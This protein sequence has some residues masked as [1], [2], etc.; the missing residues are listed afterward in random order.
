M[1]RE[2]GRDAAGRHGVPSGRAARLALAFLGLTALTATTP[3]FPLTHGLYD[4]VA[5]GLTSLAYM[6]PA[7]V[8]AMALSTVAAG[9][10]FFRRRRRFVGCAALAL[11]GFFY[12]LGIVLGL[13][14]YADGEA[15]TAMAALA[16]ALGG[17]GIFA[18]FAIWW[19]IPSMIAERARSLRGML[20]YLCAVLA[21][22]TL[23]E[24]LLSTLG[25]GPA[26][27]LTLLLAAVAAMVPTCLAL[28]DARRGRAA[29]IG[30]PPER[31]GGAA[32]RDDA[33]GGGEPEGR[34][35]GGCVVPSGPEVFELLFPGGRLVV[36]G[37][38]APDE[39]HLWRAAGVEPAPEA[40]EA[41]ARRQPEERSAVARR[42]S[43]ASPF[44]EHLR[45]AS[46]PTFLVGMPVAVFLLY[47]SSFSA[48]VP[49]SVEGQLPAFAPSVLVGCALMAL[50]CLMGDDARTTAFSFR[51]F[52]PLLGVAILGAGNIV[53]PSQSSRVVAL[54]AQGM[55]YCYGLIVTALVSYAAARHFS[56]VTLLFA[57]ATTFSVAV[58]MM[59]PYYDVTLGGLS[60]YVKSFVVTVL[61]LDLILL[62][63]SPSMFAWRDVLAMVEQP[64]GESFGDKVREAC[65]RVSSEFGLTPREAEIL[66]YL[67]RGYG[68]SY[69]AT[70]MSIKENTV[71]S[72]V[73]NI[74]SK[75][76]VSSRTEL[77]SL[78]DSYAR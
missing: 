25:R 55:C 23:C 68:A 46:G 16:G 27:V 34:G 58:A 15:S 4:L 52:L 20:L 61:V 66:R 22:G 50:L 57:C 49:G 29:G 41:G 43:G 37:G 24:T 48:L 54:G 19:L 63:A 31:E 65:D 39:A 2:G 12:L 69:L 60:G 10:L 17:V 75:L 8:T 30:V 32:G 28:A 14:A 59:M 6:R 5:P 67:G 3:A 26:S 1:A 62:I 76:D 33:A 74:Y 11:G 40:G 73:R 45:G 64:A 72:H 42:R 44:G 35:R 78:I 53:D 21:A 71:R 47:A 36:A 9:A 13:A 56:G 51:A 38:G 18:S 77:L 70:V 7:G